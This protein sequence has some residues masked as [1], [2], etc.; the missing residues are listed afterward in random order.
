[1]PIT[2]IIS[3][4]NDIMSPQC[5]LCPKPNA[6]GLTDWC[7]GNCKLD[8]DTRICK[9]SKYCSYTLTINGNYANLGRFKTSCKALLCH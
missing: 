2:D 4:G 1:M 7:G 6:T 9:E 8:E 5:R 3:C